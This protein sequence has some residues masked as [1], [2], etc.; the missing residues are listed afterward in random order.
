VTSPWAAA[1]Q[2]LAEDPVDVR[3]LSLTDL[4]ARRAACQEAETG[5]SYLRRLVQG[6]LD[7]VQAD[8]ERRRSGATPADTSSLVQQLPEILS[9]HLVG[10]GS[11]RLASVTASPDLVAEQSAALDELI[12]PRRLAAVQQVSDDDIRQLATDLADVERTVSGRRHALHKVIDELQEELVRRYKTGEAAVDT[13]L[14]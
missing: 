2:L 5:L 3:T 9:D 10:P 7:I 14:S 1:D 12:D 13:L 4:R 11:G 6:H 8:L